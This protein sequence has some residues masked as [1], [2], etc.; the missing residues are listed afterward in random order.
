MFYLLAE[1][2]VLDTTAVIVFSSILTA[3]WVL[4]KVG[5]RLWLE[6]RSKAAPTKMCEFGKENKGRIVKLEDSLNDVTVKVGKMMDFIEED[7]STHAE[8]LEQ[9]KQLNQRLFIG[10]GTKSIVSRLDVHE[11]EI[12]DLKEDVKTKKAS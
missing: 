6:P 5:D 1:G 7:R 2:I 4:V 9:L 8:I 3:I 12:K 11:N 10:N